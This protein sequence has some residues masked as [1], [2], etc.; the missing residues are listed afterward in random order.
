MRSNLVL[1]TFLSV[2]LAATAC[3]GGGN[4]GGDD[5]ADDDGANP[6]APVNVDDAEIYAIQGGTVGLGTQVNIRGVVV[7]AIDTYGERTGNFW[8]EEP[9]GGAFSGVMV[10]GA[11]V[12]QVADLAVGDV[13]DVESVVVTE[14]ALAEDTSG[15]T[16]TEMAPPDGGAITVTKVDTGTVPAPAV[17]DALAIGQL[18]DNAAEDLEWEK[19]EGVLIRLEHVTALSTLRQIGS[20]AQDPPFEEFRATG[21]IRVDTS[22]ASI[23]EI[24]SSECLASITGI[25]D[26]FFN[27]KVLPRATADV[28]HGGA[29]CPAEESESTVCQDAIDNDADDFADCADFSCSASAQCVTDT[30]VAAI[31]MGVVADGDNVN[32]SGL[33]VTAVDNIGTTSNPDS[34]KG[35]WAAD[36]AQAASQNGVYVFT[37]SAVP[38]GV[39]I[40]ATVDIA[41]TV[42]EFDFCYPSPCTV[43]GDTLTEIDARNGTVSVQVGTAEPLPLTGV[44]LNT[45]KE[46]AAGEPYES[47][48]VQLS[49]VKVASLAGGDRLTVQ[50]SNGQTIVVDDDAYDYAA[51]TYPAASGDTP[52]TCFATLTGVMS[53]NVFDNE[54]RLMPR[55]VSDMVT[56]GTCN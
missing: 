21:P 51:S 33:V 47:V 27:Y 50:D 28:V 29:G 49:N 38:A 39:V 12:D 42:D 10:Y 44:A 43:S 2:A 40:G 14:F 34:N 11:P 25:G 6:D 5:T 32:L 26:Y 54:R 37:G 55:R 22:L 17:V 19:W 35:F 36:A 13:V 24:A 20:M 7:T 46:I 18:T 15:R 23:D 52:A 1:L 30:T 31:Q 4:N 16:T 56:G 41:G 45:L 9:A 3:R 48:L 8:V 53:L